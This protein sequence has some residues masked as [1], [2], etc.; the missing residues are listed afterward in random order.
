MKRSVLVF[1]LLILLTGSA[2]ASGSLDPTM[3]VREML[4]LYWS[5]QIDE[6]LKLWHPGVDQQ[7]AR[8]FAEEMHAAG[9]QHGSHILADSLNLVKLAAT[10][11]GYDRFIVQPEAGGTLFDISLCF[12]VQRHEDGFVVLLPEKGFAED[13]T[14]LPVGEG[15]FG[16]AKKPSP[17]VGYRTAGLS[18]MRKDSAAFRAS[19]SKLIPDEVLEAQLAD[20]PDYDP[21]DPMNAFIL[22]YMASL[23][24]PI[25]V[26]DPN[27]VILT[28]PDG[29]ITGM[30]WEDGTWKLLP[31]EGLALAY[32]DFEYKGTTV[33]P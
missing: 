9:Q 16:I 32:Q 26:I 17:M 21:E 6:G 1:I 29:T 33:I 22:A 25:E 31:P 15:F 4:K 28:I 11:I 13:G 30:R 7:L 20:M 12:M 2:L 18:L 27:T 14:V 8:T 5:G 24:L 23:E 19:V 3:A 10:S